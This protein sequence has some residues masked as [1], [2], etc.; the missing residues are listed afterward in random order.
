MTTLCFVKP[1]KPP[2]SHIEGTPCCEEHPVSITIVAKR[3]GNL[4][5]APCGFYRGALG[6]TLDGLADYA[7]GEAFLY[8]FPYYWR[9]AMP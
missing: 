4:L 5:S 7:R 6:R 1:I 8:H 2:A 9:T 3:N